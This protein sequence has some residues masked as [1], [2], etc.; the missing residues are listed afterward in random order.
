MRKSESPHEAFIRTTRSPSHSLRFWEPPYCRESLHLQPRDEKGARGRVALIALDA[1]VNNEA[2]SAI[3]HVCA[4]YPADVP[5]V[6]LKPAEPRLIAAAA[7]R[8]GASG[9]RA[10]L[11]E[12]M[13]RKDLAEQLLSCK[14]QVEDVA[15]V[16]SRMH[17]R[18]TSALEQVKICIYAGLSRRRIGAIASEYGVSAATLRVH[19]VR[20]TG[21][22]PRR[23]QTL[24]SLVNL[25]Y[26]LQLGAYLEEGVAAV[27]ERLGYID[28]SYIRRA[29]RNYLGCSAGQ[30][31]SCLG[32]EWVVFRASRSVPTPDSQTLLDRKTRL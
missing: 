19:L 22:S 23:W 24:G 13:T 18:L 3:E 10:V 2:E 32:W 6:V 31:R 29:V 9:A 27:A 17:P 4:N 28:E 15:A 5:V 30:V 12:P 26:Q 14:P 16:L 11:L 20:E 1:P 8:A 7:A 21:V 25:V